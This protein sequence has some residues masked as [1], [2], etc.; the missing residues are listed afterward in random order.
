[1]RS[2]VAALEKESAWMAENADNPFIV[3]FQASIDMFNGR[4]KRARLGVERAAAMERE[5]NL[6]ETASRMLLSQA[7]S[8]LCLGKSL[9]PARPSSRRPS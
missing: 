6:K 5:S 1:M 7:R 4:F 9:R 8:D 2:D 3:S